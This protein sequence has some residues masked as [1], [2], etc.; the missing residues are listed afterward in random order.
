MAV[1]RFWLVRFALASQSSF[2]EER[3][4]T[5]LYGELLELITDRRW[6]TGDRIVAANYVVDPV[7]T[8][9]GD[10]SLPSLMHQALQDVPASAE[11]VVLDL[12]PAVQA[13]GVGA[14]HPR[15][16]LDAGAVLAQWL[17]EQKD[18]ITRPSALV[19]LPDLED[20]D[21]KVDLLEFRTLAASGFATLVDPEGRSAGEEL[22]P[23]A[24]AQLFKA[25]R[26]PLGD[27]Q[28]KLIRRWGFFPT[29]GS[30]RATYSRIYYDGRFCEEEL[31]RL[32]IDRVAQ[33]VNDARSLSKNRVSAAVVCADDNS[34]WLA[35]P[36]TRAVDVVA[37]REHLDHGQLRAFSSDQI[38]EADA[39]KS[40]QHVL[41]VVGVVENG[42]S[43]RELHDTAR[44]WAP[45]ATFEARC[46]VF[47]AD[48][49]PTLKLSD[50][51][52]LR[53]EVLVRGEQETVARAKFSPDAAYFEAEDGTEDRFLE[54]TSI[55]FWQLAMEAGFIPEVDPPTAH[56][57][58]LDVVPNFVEFLELNGAWVASKIERAINQLTDH[59][60]R[61]VGLVLVAEEM[62]ANALAD[63]L[64]ETIG[65]NP[66]RIPRKAFT[67]WTKDPNRAQ[68]KWR[69]DPP[70][71]LQNVKSLKMDVDA[72]VIVDEFAYTGQT[73]ER[74]AIMLSGINVDVALILS[75]ATFSRSSYEQTLQ[76]WP[77]MALYSTEWRLPDAEQWVEHHAEEV[78][79]DGSR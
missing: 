12:R 67:E 69:D 75:I 43:L 1:S 41:L 30:S 44:V 22:D 6:T 73:L 20:L 42:T 28:R 59:T 63:V 71:W 54:F 56:R 9:T 35:G 47:A 8:K 65:N 53:F 10:A 38:R 32:F 17:S 76:S 27:L 15:A 7:S 57:P 46:V 49:D 39:G 2:P 24:V 5:P 64:A 48:T 74:L 78:A 34:P 18:D 26:D 77:H 40:F 61:D 23:G 68:R 60:T 3:L 79:P 52:K 37:E 45:A 33:L 4:T 13:P 70:A 58:Q 50:G 16:N 66:L 14:I 62:G 51:T 31:E 25:Q 21:R 55:D 36:V 72:F 29:H 19:V 11:A